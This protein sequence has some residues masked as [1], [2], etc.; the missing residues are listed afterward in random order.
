[1]AIL[2]PLSIK[3]Q[4]AENPKAEPKFWVDGT[5]SQ[6]KNIKVSD[7]QAI[8]AMVALMDMQAVLGGA[9]SHWGGPA[10]L[11]EIW[12]ALHALV[13]TES[14]QKNTPWNQL[15]HLV[16][17]AGHCENALYAIKANY[18]F[19]D[20]NI[21]SL[22]GFRSLQS[23]LTGHGE[24]HLF[25]QGVFISNGPLGSSL[26]QS[27]GLCFA[28][29]LSG[30]QRMTITTISDGACMEGEAKEALAAI[31]GL[32]AKG[33]MAPFVLIISDNNTKLS[34]RIDEQSYS[35][36]PTFNSLPSLGWK[37][38]NLEKGNH[39]PSCLTALEEAMAWAKAHPEMPV[40]IHAKTIK[41]FGV[42]KTQDSA[43]G[44]HGFP[45]SDPNDLTAFL[46][47]IYCSK[48]VPEVF[49][50]W[51]KE[52]EEQVAKA[53]KAPSSGPKEKVQ[54]GVSDALI[55]KVKEGYPVFSISSDLAGS[56]G[57]SAFQK[58]C[59]NHFYDIGIAESNMVSVAAGLSKAG[60]IPVVDTF[61]QFGVTKGALPFL[62]ANISG[63]PM[64][65]IFSHA[66]FQDA[67]DGA[68]HQ[69][70]T[71]FSMLGSIPNTKLYALSTSE[72][73]RSLVGQAI[74]E[75]AEDR[76]AGRNPVNSV[77]F[78]GRESF[79]REIKKGLSYRLGE[80]Q[81]LFD[82]TTEF[83]KSVTLLSAGPLVHQAL[84][85]TEALKKV[86]I[87]SIVINASVVNNPDVKTIV[88]GL[89]KTQ[90]NL[91]TI[92]DHQVLG[93]LGGF[94]AHALSLEGHSYQLR[95]LGVQGVFGQSAYTALELYSEHSLDAVA[96][97]QAAEELLKA[98]S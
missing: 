81:I 28:D 60:Y 73:A 78:L 85:A 83:K 3:N 51:Q 61:A 19:A 10:A 69:A 67:A 90:G 39:L 6:G 23:P 20:L 48:E 38:I 79:V 84:L 92:E 26:P 22:K 17:D 89:K 65:S 29:A 57:L 35:M 45:L 32:A 24:S 30:N 55:A 80:A 34:G 16:N 76:K 88:M 96:I 1:M 75:F 77:F 97:V 9:A 68:S 58:E 15:Y 47:E 94:T 11:S 36:A 93:G 71:Y 95:S 70:L 13:F 41:G 42:K 12:S 44:G 37:V 50:S 72:E 40:A 5:L 14:Q 27:Q 2:E 21:E 43:S 49:K 64:I 59:P 8:R 63:A 4:L 46:S 74:V 54:L 91:M 31:P 86:G 25:P 82:N 18:G 52:M 53:V 66:G 87:G 56:T 62:M 98:K 7:P 33:K